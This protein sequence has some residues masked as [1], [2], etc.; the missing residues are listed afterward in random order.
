MKR[1]LAFTIVAI[2]FAVGLIIVILGGKLVVS[3]FI[4]ASTVNLFPDGCSYVV[5]DSLYNMPDFERVRN[6]MSSNEIVKSIPDKGSVA[7][8]FFHFT[9][10]CRV[11]DKYFFLSGGKIDERFEQAD[12]QIWIHSDYVDRISEANFCEIVK[13]AINNGDVGQGSVSNEITLLWRYRS[14]L[15]HRACFGY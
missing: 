2:C 9:D 8:G 7:L 3:G 1:A 10:G 15:K 14:M 5:D 13:E 11:W 4:T 6:I 12:I